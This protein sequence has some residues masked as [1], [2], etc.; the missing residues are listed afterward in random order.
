M[1]ICI[2]IIDGITKSEE[3]IKEPIVFAE[4]ATAIAVKKLIVKFNSLTLRPKIWEEFG[5][6]SKR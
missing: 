6:K 1:Q 2:A 4:I 5:S 3:T